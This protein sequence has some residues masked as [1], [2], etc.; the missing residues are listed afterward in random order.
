MPITISKK[1]YWDLVCE[2][3]RKKHLN[4]NDKF[5]VT[6]QYP[7]QLGQGTYR[8]IQ[9]RQGVELAIDRYQ[10][11]DDV[12]VQSSERSHSLE[13]EFRVSGTHTPDYIAAGQYSLCGSGIAPREKWERSATEPIVQVSVHIEPEVFQTFLGDRDLASMGLDHLI[14]E[15]D[16]YYQRRDTTTIAMQ[17]VLHQILHCPFHDITKKIYLE[18][19]VW[20]L[21]ALLIEEEKERHQSKRS[22]FTL[23]PDDIDRI[24]HAKEI[25]TQQSDR[26]PLL[27]DLARQ[28]GLNDCTLK[29]GFREVFGTTAFGYLH[30]YRLEQA[31]QLLL[32][33]RFNVSEIAIQ[34]GF[35]SCSYLSRVFRR[36]YGVSPKQY[37]AQYKNSV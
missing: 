15:S 17:T 33:N 7:E 9:L 5:D 1:D 3:Q 6:W 35:G 14:K 37:Q 31:R 10:L 27:L 25:L 20:E 28:V 4:H 26:P 2:T 32:E 22:A 19:K 18:S 24:Y 13:Y 11:Y 12:I 36:K 16:I 23:K 34:V 29:R 8:E 21:M 30:D